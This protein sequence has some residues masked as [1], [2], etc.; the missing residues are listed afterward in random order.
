MIGDLNVS[1]EHENLCKAASFIKVSFVKAGCK[2]YSFKFNLNF[3]AK[4]HNINSLK[5]LKPTKI[6]MLKSLTIPPPIF[7]ID[8]LAVSKVYSYRT[9]HIILTHTIKNRL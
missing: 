6:S 1:I 8:N 4:K 2:V 7:L 5:R 3:P 9:S